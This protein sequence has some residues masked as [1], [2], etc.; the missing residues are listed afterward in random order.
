MTMLLKRKPRPGYREYRFDCLCGLHVRGRYAIADVNDPGELDRNRAVCRMIR[1]LP[2][3][4]RG[5]LSPKSPEPHQVG[6][7]R[8]LEQVDREREDQRL[9]ARQAA[10]RGAA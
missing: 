1:G 6:C 4:A 2:E 5:K 9:I 3:N 10:A 8:T 7:G